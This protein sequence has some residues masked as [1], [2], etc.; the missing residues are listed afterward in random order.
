MMR[1]HG[2]ILKLKSSFTQIVGSSTKSKETEKTAKIFRDV[3]EFV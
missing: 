1:S 3:A 2:T